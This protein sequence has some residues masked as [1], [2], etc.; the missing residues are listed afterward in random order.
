MKRTITVIWCLLALAW[1]GLRFGKHLK[2]QETWFHHCPLAWTGPHGSTQEYI[3]VC[4]ETGETMGTIYYDSWSESWH[5]SE[6]ETLVPIVT[7]RR[8][9][10]EAKKL[11]EDKFK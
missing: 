4:S 7:N 3:Y 9:L 11:I 1:I 2:F 6:F 8:T 10:E 5:V